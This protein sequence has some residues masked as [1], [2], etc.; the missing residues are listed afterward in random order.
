MIFERLTEHMLTP[1]IVLKE[2]RPMNN[3]HQFGHLSDHGLLQFWPI[4][5]QACTYTC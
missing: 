2:A 4:T 3:T 1:D 5:I